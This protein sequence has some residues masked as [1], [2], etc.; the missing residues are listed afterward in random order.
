MNRPMQSL[1]EAESMLETQSLTDFVLQ[2]ARSGKSKTRE[3]H[4]FLR[5]LIFNES[6]LAD[7]DTSLALDC[8]CDLL[9]PLCNLYHL[10]N[11]E[12]RLKGNRNLEGVNC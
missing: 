10:E 6:L 3:R 11:S 12:R 5:R 1:E 4:L 9:V 8:I 7:L 2:N